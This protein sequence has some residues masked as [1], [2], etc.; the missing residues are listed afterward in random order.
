MEMMSEAE[1]FEHGRLPRDCLAS[2]VVAGLQEPA[3][4]DLD[5]EEEFLPVEDDDET[6]R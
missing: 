5:P 1:R 3:I 2:F 4:F 6:A